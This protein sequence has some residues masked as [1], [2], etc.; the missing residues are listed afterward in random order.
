M[1]A[2][3]NSGKSETGFLIHGRVQGV[4][5][6]WWTQREARRLGVMGTVR[7]VEDGT[8]EVMARG[9]EDALIRLELALRRGP[10]MAQVARVERIPFALDAGPTDFE[11]VR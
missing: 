2:Q 9:I 8:V 6:R 4:G 7:N 1:N 10:P 3:R 11:I 5:Y